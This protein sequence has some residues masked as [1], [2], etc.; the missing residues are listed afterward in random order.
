MALRSIASLVTALCAFAVTAVHA[1]VSERFEVGIRLRVDPLI[2]SRRITGLMKDETDAIWRPYGIQLEWTDAAASEPAPNSV[3]L[4]AI[5]ERQF[6]RP[7]RM[8]WPTILG[9]A[10]V[11]S[12]APNWGPIR[13]SFDATELVLRTTGRATTAG[14]VLDRELARALGR[15]LAHEIGHVLLGVRDHDRAG[16]MR[17]AFPADQLAEPDRTPFRLTC[18]GVDR[19]R[20][21]LRGF[22]DNPQPGLQHNSTTLDLEGFRGTRSESPGG[23]SCIRIQHAR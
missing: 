2:A 6:E 5:V 12:D 18:S 22:A 21:R 7:E 19:L 10:F 1:D 20:S 14:L 23:T 4:D 13:V 15:V 8:G 3:S 11:K 16:L 9:R 17:A